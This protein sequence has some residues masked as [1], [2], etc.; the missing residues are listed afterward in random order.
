MKSSYLEQSE[1]D[2]IHTVSLWTVYRTNIL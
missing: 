1:V 2:N